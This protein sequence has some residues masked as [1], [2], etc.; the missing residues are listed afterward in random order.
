MYNFN[1][2]GSSRAHVFRHLPDGTVTGGQVHTALDRLCGTAL[3]VVLGKARS[4]ALIGA[5]RPLTL[6]AVAAGSA[7]YQ[8]GERVLL[9]DDDTF[10][11]VDRGHVQRVGIDIPHVTELTQMFF[12]EGMLH[13]VYRS[14]RA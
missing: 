13:D 7:R 6:V 4:K 2:P 3:C 8:F 9:V 14:A 5:T 11:V 1:S 10:L 12:P